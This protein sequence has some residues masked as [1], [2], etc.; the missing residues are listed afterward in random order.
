M[1]TRHRDEKAEKDKR[2]PHVAGSSECYSMRLKKQSP[3]M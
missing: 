2:S 1:R 3:L